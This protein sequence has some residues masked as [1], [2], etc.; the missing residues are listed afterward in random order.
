MSTSSLREIQQ[1]AYRAIL[2]EEN[3]VPMTVARAARLGVY[4]NNARE[5]FRKTLAVTYPVV[6][7]LVGEPCFRGIA[8]H[9]MREF[10]S[11][12]GDLGRFGAELATLL[13]IY[14]RDTEFA[15]LADV[16][17]LE[18]ACAEA[19]IAAE[20][21]PL[22]LLQLAIVD[23]D[24]HPAL[25]FAMR[26]PVRFVS[27]RYPVL[28]IWEANQGDDVAP[29]DLAAGA[30]HVLVMR[31]AARVR[32]HRLDSATFAFAR[33]LADGEPLADAH[34]AG[35]VAADDFDASRALVLLAGLDVLA[36]FRAPSH[37]LD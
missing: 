17:R 2:W 20:G 24:E 32:L 16:A 29:V 15:Y 9:F 30:D 36:S 18:W 6:Q 12:G 28:R 11:R 33:S 14:Y 13:D 27:S 34:E 10:P 35:R 5:T 19:E 4:R 23:V 3:V 31:R 7:R 25:R 8:G 1:R 26:P 22:D 21:F 37:G